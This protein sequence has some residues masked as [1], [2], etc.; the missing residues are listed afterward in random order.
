MNRRRPRRRRRVFTICRRVSSAPRLNSWALIASWA[1]M[2]VRVSAVLSLLSVAAIML[3]ARTFAQSSTDSGQ[4]ES[5]DRRLNQAFQAIVERNYDQGRKLLSDLRDELAPAADSPSTGTQLAEAEMLG[6]FI[7]LES[8]GA[9]PLAAARAYLLF[10][11]ASRRFQTHWLPDNLT[12]PP[13]LDDLLTLKRTLDR[14][15]SAP[16]E[17]LANL[18][19]PVLRYLVF[20]ASD[21]GYLFRTR[22]YQESRECYEQALRLW[23]LAHA[24]DSAADRTKINIHSALSV[25][26]NH[27]GSHH[28]ALQHAQAAVR[29]AEQLPATDRN[30]ADFA[31]WLINLGAVYETV[32]D[33][34][35]ARSQYEAAVAQVEG[36]GAP[37]MED[38][39]AAEML[40]SGLGHLAALES[41]VGQSEQ[42]IKRSLEVLQVRT[43]LDASEEELARAY[44]NLAGIYAEAGRVADAES[45]FDRALAA[46]RQ[47]YSVD[48]FPHGHVGLARSLH[49]YAE[50]ALRYGDLTRAETTA[51]EA[52]AMREAN[53]PLDAFPNGHSE[54]ADSWALLGRIQSELGRTAEARRSLGEA[55]RI[56]DRL[57]TQ[58][59][60]GA[61]LDDAVNFTSLVREIR[62]TLLSLPNDSGVEPTELYRQVW[63][64]KAMTSRQIRQRNLLWTRSGD[65]RADAVR[66]RLEDISHRFSVVVADR[67]TPH[68]AQVEALRQLRDEQR[69]STFELYEL[70]KIGP[71]DDLQPADLAARLGDDAALVDIVR[72]TSVRRR[73]NDTAGRYWAFVLRGGDPIPVRIDLGSADELDRLILSFHDAVS[74][75]APDSTISAV[76]AALGKQ[77]WSRLEPAL[78]RSARVRR[79]LIAADSAFERLPWDALPSVTSRRFLIEDYDI[80]RVIHGALLAE[81]LG[82]SAESPPAERLRAMIVGDVDFGSPGGRAPAEFV[83][84]PDTADELRRVATLLEG[85]G[86][87]PVTRFAGDAATADDVATQLKQAHLVHLATHLVGDRGEERK[88][89]GTESPNAL[90]SLEAAGIALSGANNTDQNVL[91]GSRITLLPLSDLWLVNLAGCHGGIGAISSGETGVSSLEHAFQLAGA[92]VTIASQWEADSTVAAFTMS[93][94]YRELLTTPG[95][96]AMQALR[97]AKLAV[98]ERGPASDA[99][100]PYYWANWHATGPPDVVISRSA[101][102]SSRVARTGDAGAVEA[103]SA[104]TFIA[105]IDRHPRGAAPSSLTS[106]WRSHGTTRRRILIP[107]GLSAAAAL[108]LLLAFRTSTKKASL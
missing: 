58:F 89:R 39:E 71:G 62:D 63:T 23:K 91:R 32:G 74:S 51:R 52:L 67:K 103:R 38:R 72:T 107:L 66:R 48:K 93:E 45:W 79:V 2:C 22:H 47:V 99:D 75:R 65:P 55:A 21:A 31:A 68:A 60:A 50:F 19:G 3:S 27:S 35:A 90:R 94:F 100:H 73:G 34:T 28:E 56:A 105:G 30:P 106:T 7:E 14:F 9:N 96:D 88:N 5:T 70:L 83:S 18:P 59:I 97:S 24:P 20:A 43:R 8:S 85:E 82:A 40:A 17:R 54:L 86:V 77:V 4:A 46:R 101:F 10:D 44:H 84:L 69:R 11:K 80:A 6:A 15:Q 76:G 61:T 41:K 49:L 25:L 81:Q 92:R 42:A 16:D 78:N 64:S 108:C 13:R 29:A 98:L 37:P 53:Y 57:A 33:H 104:D 12:S 1:R 102:A 87:E 36:A 95:A 26:L